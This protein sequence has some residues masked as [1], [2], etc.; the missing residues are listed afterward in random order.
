MRGPG[1]HTPPAD[2]Q[3]QPAHNDSVTVMRQAHRWNREPGTWRE[4]GPLIHPEAAR[5]IAAWWQSPGPAGLPFA[6]FASTGTLTADLAPAIERELSD[7]T[8]AAHLDPE[9]REARTALRAL[10]AYLD[11]CPVTVWRV[12]H[13]PTP[14]AD[15]AIVAS[16]LTWPT[17]REALHAHLDEYAATQWPAGCD[18]DQNDTDHCHRCR[19]QHD[20][21][22]WLAGDPLGFDATPDTAA[23][24]FR[25]ERADHNAA[26]TWR[27]ERHATTYGAE[28]PPSPPAP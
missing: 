12:T 14:T 20:A 10:R 26:P 7:L 2:T 13:T 27:V 1:T 6:A 28:F 16:A 22:G 25:H 8:G 9:T 15:P 3:P 11:A 18:T 21:A 4:H 17:T 23:H 5:E 19:F 24:T